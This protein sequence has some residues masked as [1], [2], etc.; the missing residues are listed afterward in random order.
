MIE[1]IASLCL[2]IITICILFL[3]FKDSFKKKNNTQK[4]QR[5]II[6]G[7]RMYKPT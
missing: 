7:F 5:V 1:V 4:S 3:S 6:K 2:L